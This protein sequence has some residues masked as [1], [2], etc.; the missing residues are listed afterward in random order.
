[1]VASPVSFH[2]RK[3]VVD[4]TVHY[5]H[6]T[7]AVEVGGEWVVLSARVV[8]ANASGHHPHAGEVLP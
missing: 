5:Y 8:I 4:E 1:M 6:S 2:K 7:A 3:R